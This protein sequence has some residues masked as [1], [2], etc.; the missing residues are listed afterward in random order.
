MLKTFIVAYVVFA[1]LGA[2]GCVTN[3]YEIK[4]EKPTAPATGVYKTVFVGWLNLGRHR[5]KDLGFINQAEWDTEIRAV[6]VEWLHKAAKSE[7]S[8]KKLILAK[9]EAARPSGGGVAVIFVN[10]LVEKAYT[11]NH[12]YDFIHSDII[13]TDLRK[14]KVVYRCSI[15][16]SNKSFTPH[17]YRFESRLGLA[18]ANIMNFIASKL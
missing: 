16:A 18:A 5:W 7:L 17:N 6:N 11:A 12:P 2:A 9:S 15:K 1:L 8:S 14:G 10:T 3:K 4:S 13:F